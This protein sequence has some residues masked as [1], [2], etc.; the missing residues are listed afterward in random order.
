MRFAS[1]EASSRISRASSSAWRV[2]S[3]ALASAAEM[4]ARTCSLAVV[5]TVSVRWRAERL[6]PSTGSATSRRCVSTA[7]GS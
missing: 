2:I 5:A 3:E 7:S 1:A 4:I 6:I